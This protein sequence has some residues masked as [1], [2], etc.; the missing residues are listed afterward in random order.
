MSEAEGIRVFA[1]ARDEYV[2]GA[3]IGY[4]T[5][6]GEAARMMRKFLSERDGADYEDLTA[7][8]VYYS[9]QLNAYFIED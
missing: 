6:A 9:R 2:D 3:H 8:T 1:C 5:S 4:A 7:R